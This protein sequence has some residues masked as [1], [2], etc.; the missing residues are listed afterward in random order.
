[1]AF[2]DRGAR[3]VLLWELVSGLALTFT[4][5]FKRPVTVN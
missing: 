4:Y 2:L 5:M 3:T 1:M